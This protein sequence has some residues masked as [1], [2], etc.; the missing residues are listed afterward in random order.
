MREQ[1]EKYD[2]PKGWTVATI[3]ELI[4]GKDGLFKD[5]DWIE[6]KDQNPE[7]EVRLIQLADIG[8]GF[9]RN[10]SDRYMTKEKALELNCT[11]LKKGDILVARMPDP[12]GRACIFPYSEEEKYVTVVDVAIIRT[13]QNGVDNRYLTHFINSPGIRKNIERFQT[14]TTRKRISRGNL[15][16]IK[17]PIPPLKEQN[18]I[19]SKIDELFSELDKGVASLKHIQN[20]LKV[21]RLALLKNAFE[22]KLT[23]KWREENKPESTEKLLEHIKIERQD[24]YQQELNEWKEI[25]K[26][27]D[28]I[29]KKPEKPKHSRFI[30]ANVESEI[31]ILPKIPNEWKYSKLGN[32]GNMG[33]GKSKHRPRNDV[34][35]FGGDYPFIQT[36]EV[37]NSN[38][39]IRK[40]KKTYSDFGLEQSKLWKKGTLCITIAANIAETAFLG[41]DACFPDSVVGFIPENDIS[42]KFVFHFIEYSKK[43][44]QEFAPA[45]AQKNINLNILDNLYI[46]LCS[47]EE[48]IEIVNYLDSAFSIIDNLENTIEYSFNKSGSTSQSIL[49]KA[50]EG[51]LISQDLN[52]EP[53]KNLLRR[54]EIEKKKKLE[55]LKQNKINI[56]KKTKKMDKSLIEIIKNNFKEREFNYEELKAETNLSYDDLKKQLFELL[57][58]GDVLSFFDKS[59]ET[60]KYQLL[61]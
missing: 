17:I 49:K 7:G 4:D 37:R 10:R 5:G 32:I 8:D 16:T 54:I 11:F 9:F 45:T 40:Y 38:I 60:I 34:R 12:L 31:S 25:V 41:F 22:G 1:Q 27:W 21:Y 14:G 61:K 57:E 50:V 28:K 24:Y 46:P 55:D 39:V 35:L 29:S 13:G 20:Q 58:K 56:P 3:E 53:A 43:R 6:T 30:G 19:A 47:A 42:D 36:S 48:Q 52:D 26:T 2:L 33:R 15:A 51:I 18:K 59:A 23:E 44:I